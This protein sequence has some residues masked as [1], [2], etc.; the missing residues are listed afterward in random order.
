[1]FKYFIPLILTSLLGANTLMVKSI[2]SLDRPFMVKSSEA[3]FDDSL[4]YTHKPLLDC[5]PKLNAVYKIVSEK[6]LK[7]IKS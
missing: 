1:M 4:S 5:S 6:E 7:V 3:L 2:S